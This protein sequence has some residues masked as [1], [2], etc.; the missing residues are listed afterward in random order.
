MKFAIL[1]ANRGF[2]PSSVIE[3]AYADMRAVAEKVGVVLLEI[4]KDKVKYGAVET[5]A[6]GMIYHDFLEAHRGEYDGVIICLPNFGDENGIKAALCDVN[7]PVLLQAYPDEIGKMDFANRRD[8]FCG[9]LGLCAVFKQ[10]GLRFTSGKPFAMHPLSASFEKELREFV[11]ICRVVKTLRHMRLGVFGARTTAFKSV[12][13]DE[14]AM[15][16]FGCD[17]E[18]IDLTQIFSKFKTIDE[19]SAAAMFFAKKLTETGDLSDTPDYAKKN[20]AILGATFKALIDEMKLD[21]IAI[22]CWSELQYEYKIAPCAPMGILNQMGIPAVCETDATNAIAMMAL[23]L[24]SGKPTGCLDINNN[25]GEEENKCILFHCG[26]LPI[27]L[28]VKPG[29]VEEHMMFVKTQGKNCSWGV[30]VGHIKP[31]PITI[32]GMH[33][34]NGQVRF[35]VEKAEITN[36]PVEE[37]FFG[38]SG[39]MQMGNLQ[40]KLYTMA[41]EGFRHHAIITTGDHVRAVK[42][43]LSKYLGYTH[44]ALL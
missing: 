35:F 6:E 11:S 22:R 1:V 40:D 26:P 36:D 29:H 37:A 3:S 19:N 28:M 44:I 9:K 2:F 14:S 41:N 38:T 43:A 16:K 25:Y 8:A 20:L 27:D 34:E 33:T 24:A 7:V 30:N 18:T 17:V 13:F 23:T 42:E 15:E 21:A 39:V 12:R 10:M 5:T 32:S 4:E 31:G